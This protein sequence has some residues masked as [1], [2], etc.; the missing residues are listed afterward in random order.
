MKKLPEIPKDLN[1]KYQAIA[2]FAVVSIVVVSVGSVILYPNTDGTLTLKAAAATITFWTL[3]LGVVFIRIFLKV[4]KTKSDLLSQA[5]N[6]PKNKLLDDPDLFKHFDQQNLINRLVVYNNGDTKKLKKMYMFQ[7]LGLAK[8]IGWL[9]SFVLITPLMLVGLIPNITPLFIVGIGV[10][11]FFVSYIIDIIRG[12][13]KPEIEALGLN[14]NKEI[15]EADGRFAG[16]EVNLAFTNDSVTT[17]ANKS[18]EKFTAAFLK[19]EFEIQHQTPGKIK[20]FLASL[21]QKELWK[22]VTIESNGTTIKIERNYRLFDG[23]PLN[24][25]WSC[26]LWL[27]HRLG[28]L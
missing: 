2:I 12:E 4:A 17:T 27:L 23:S 24:D 18:A 15:E 6:S 1:N 11:Y 14:W 16:Q 7:N 28:T 25:Y 26:D 9:Y 21:D 3:V 20:D 10:A 13:T 8:L 19:T 22:G 5:V